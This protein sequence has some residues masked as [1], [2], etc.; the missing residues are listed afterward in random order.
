MS[1]VAALGPGV[2]PLI[3]GDKTSRIEP[4]RR[5]S[6]MRALSRRG[7][8]FAIALLVLEDKSPDRRGMLMFAALRYSKPGQVALELSTLSHPQDS[9]S[10]SRWTRRRIGWTYHVQQ[11]QAYSAVRPKCKSRRVIV[12]PGAGGGGFVVAL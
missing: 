9:H 11:A 12:I 4:I 3:W 5:V 6:R 10:N 2:D 7:R 8:D 1:S